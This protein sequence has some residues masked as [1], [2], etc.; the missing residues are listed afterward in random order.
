M[1]KFLV[2]S[3]QP[4]N[5]KCFQVAKY[6]CFKMSVVALESDQAREIFI[7][8]RK[9]IRSAIYSWLSKSLDSKQ[10]PHLTKQYPNL[11][12]SDRNN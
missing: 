3:S 7:G 2:F 4:K 8:L 12:I 9:T 6:L 10:I 5:L 11:L 1:F